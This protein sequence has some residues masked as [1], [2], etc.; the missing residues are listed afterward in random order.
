[1]ASRDEKMEKA[2]DKAI[3]RY[4]RD[5]VPTGDGSKKL[6]RREAEDRA[7]DLARKVDRER[8]K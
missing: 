4:M 3:E 5:G 1:M 6:T 7:G 2:R 8:G